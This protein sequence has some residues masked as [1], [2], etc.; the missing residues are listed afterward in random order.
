MGMSYFMIPIFP[1]HV[2]FSYFSI[3]GGNL[4][5]L[6]HGDG[7]QQRSSHCHCPQLSSQ[8]IMI[9]VI[10]I[11]TNKLFQN[12]K[13]LQILTNKFTRTPETHDMPT[14]VSSKTNRSYDKTKL[15]RNLDKSYQKPPRCKGLSIRGCW[16]PYKFCCPR[17]I[18]NPEGVFNKRLLATLIILNFVANNLILAIPPISTSIN[19]SSSMYYFLL[20]WNATC[21]RKVKE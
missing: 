8:V 12:K 20:G 15:D 13:Q 14:W 11:I 19:L 7:C 16:Q 6:H 21:Q 17:V 2:G 9:W 5:Q 4:L 10:Q 18:R 3:S 1:F